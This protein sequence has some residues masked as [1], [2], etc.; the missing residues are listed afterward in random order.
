MG[1]AIELA[2]LTHEYGRENEAATVRAIRDLT[3]SI[4][5]GAFVVLMG[6]S[7][8]GKSTLLNLLGGVEKPTE[9]I[10]SLDGS[11]ITQFSEQ[12][13]TI[14]RRRSIGYIFQFFNLLPGLTVEENAAFPLELND[15][16]PAERKERVATALEEVGLTPRAQHLPSML[17]GG[18]MQRVAIA[19]AI[20]HRPGLILA[21]EPT[22]N[23]DSRTGEQILQLLAALH[24]DHRP[25]FV[26]AT[27]S[28]HAASFGDYILRISDGRITT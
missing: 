3:L 8:S 4:E 7:G 11:D 10:V 27:H 19:R 6:E 1:V 13:L 26:M 18:E 2:N 17:S 23:L 28:D 14:L 21:D 16:P 20:I 24:R 9:G 15:V 25:T 5:P 12:Q 22:G